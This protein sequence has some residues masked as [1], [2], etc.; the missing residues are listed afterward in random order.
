LSEYVLTQLVLL[1]P[2]PWAAVVPGI[3]LPLFLP[4]LLL[5]LLLLLLPLDI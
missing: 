5:L 1:A 2:V 4:S 3:L